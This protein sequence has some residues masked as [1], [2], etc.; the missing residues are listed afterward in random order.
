[1]KPAY[2]LGILLLVSI[3]KISPIYF[4]L[5]THINKT[6][7]TNILLLWNELSG[8]RT[9]DDIVDLF[10]FKKAV[11]LCTSMC[12][13]INTPFFLSLSPFHQFA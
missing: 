9:H 6:N 13:M 11:P 1:M 2:H 4:N 5:N 10:P 3:L 7:M 12:E 8:A